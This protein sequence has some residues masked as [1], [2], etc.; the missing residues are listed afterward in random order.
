M[1]LPKTSDKLKGTWSIDNSAKNFDLSLMVTEPIEKTG[2]VGLGFGCDK[3]ICSEFWFCTVN[4]TA[5]TEK[6]IYDDC[7]TTSY[8]D[9]EGAVSCCVAPGTTHVTPTCFT[10]EEAGYYPLNVV[11]S[12]MTNTFTSINMRAP[13]CPINTNNGDGEQNSAASNCFNLF[14]MTENRNI[15][16]IAAY[17]TIDHTRPH[18]PSSR[19]SGK[20]NLSTGFV[21]STG[22]RNLQVFSV[23]GCLML[24]AWLFCAP[25]GIYIV[26][27]R[28]S[29]QWRVE[30]HISIM[31]IVAALMLPLILTADQSVENSAN[32]RSYHSLM[33]RIALPVMYFLM[34]IAG[35]IRYHHLS[36]GKFYNKWIGRRG[37]SFAF[38]F[39]RVMGVLT[40]LFAWSNCYTG[41]VQ[42]GTG[43]A[44]L[45]IA[46]YIFN[47]ARYVF[48]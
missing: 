40:L 42:I 15:D 14:G 19:T 25:L 48:F 36:G 32:K 31:S 16:F 28:K 4:R 26:H 23:H 10:E 33:G 30:A 22:T 35:Y 13:I 41:L 8:H 46:L 9:I 18:G 44:Q 5:L 47:D 27:C 34:I 39:H 20:M 21:T 45:D 2:F 1:I 37:N 11:D 38:F 43:T 7:D 29:Y 3:M 24:F 17:N 6:N 12:C